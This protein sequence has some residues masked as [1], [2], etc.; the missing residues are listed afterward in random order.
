M[1][2]FVLPHSSFNAFA[3]DVYHFANNTKYPVYL[4][5]KVVLVQYYDRALIEGIPASNDLNLSVAQ[6]L[7]PILIRRMIL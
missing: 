7:S 5:K 4:S 3:Q 2:A 6:P 1:I